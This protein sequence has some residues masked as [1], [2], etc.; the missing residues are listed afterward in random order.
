MAY[1]HARD[2]ARSALVLLHRIPL[3][4][5]SSLGRRRGEQWRQPPNRVEP[6]T[7]AS[8]DLQEKA[9]RHLWMHFTRM[10]AYDQEHEIPIIVRGEGSLRLRRAR[11]ALP[12]R[13]VGAL[14][15]ERRPRP[16]GAGRRRRRAGEG[17]RL[18]HELELRAPAGDRA[19]RAH[20]EPRP[21][22]TSTASSSPRAGPRRWSP[23]GSWRAQYHKLTGEPREDEDHRARD[24][25]PRHD[26]GAAVDH[27]HHPAAHAVR[28]A[29]AR[30]AATC[31]TRTRT[32]GPRSATRSGRPTR[33]S[34]MIEFQGPETVAAVILEPVQNS[35]GCFVPP[36][37]LLA[38]RARDLRPPRRAA[39]LRRGHL[40]LGPARPLLRLSSASDT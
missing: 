23:R 1:A 29:R 5:S 10:G 18:L 25:L 19:R 12:R 31:R 40:L 20:R 30:R 16:R 35:G 24:R 34:S 32:A 33:S 8:S 14:L 26:L 39:D 11:Q 28:A 17:A 15:R 27:R 9:R 3:S 38:A 21:R 4:K 2:F 13:P 22:A 7:G 37:R 36:G 6:H